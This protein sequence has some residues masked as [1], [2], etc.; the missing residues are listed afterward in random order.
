MCSVSASKTFSI[1]SLL[2]HYVTYRTFRSQV[3]TLKQYFLNAKL[4]WVLARQQIGEWV[5]GI[6]PTSFVLHDR[7]LPADIK[8]VSHIFS[9]LAEFIWS[10]EQAENLKRISF[11]IKKRY[12]KKSSFGF[13]KSSISFTFSSV[14]KIIKAYIGMCSHEKVLWQPKLFP[15]KCQSFTENS[16][17]YICGLLCSVR[18]RQGQ[19]VTV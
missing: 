7:H 14:H 12:K 17:N 11:D 5:S 13:V 16:V 10:H 1:F 6:Y 2:T 4:Q 18:V 8:T 15:L 19:Y 3:D 9:S